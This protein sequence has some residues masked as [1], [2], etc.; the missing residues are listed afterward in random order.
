[1]MNIL[2]VDDEPEIL[3]GLRRMLRG[4][5]DR[6][7]MQFASSSGEALEAMDATQ[8]DVIVS[9]MRMPGMD[10]ASL[11]TEA[12]DRQPG[13]VRIVLSGQSQLSNS[14][15]SLPVA[16]QF[17]A[18]PCDP[19]RLEAA[20]ERSLLLRDRMTSP[21]LRD[22]VGGLDC[23]PSP[24]GTVVALQSALAVRPV[25]PDRVT[26]LINADIAIST[27]VL[28]VAN[29]AFFGLP[30]TLAD[31]VEAVN[32][33]GA[34]A[35]CELVMSSEV[36][37]SLAGSN[38]RVDAEIERVQ[39][40]GTMR[41][42][43]ASELARRAGRSAMAAREIWVSAFLADVGCLLLIS[44]DRPSCAGWDS[45]AAEDTSLRTLVPT[46]GGYLISMWGLPHHLVEAVALSNDRPQPHGSDPAAFTWVAR[47]LLP[48][49]P[50]RDTIT[51]DDLALVGIAREDLDAVA[52][53]VQE[54]ADA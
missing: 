36:F 47:H 12:R 21:E 45:G 42:D 24:S 1:M 41:A 18:K 50:D 5:R 4:R 31:P 46:I 33:L 16:H 39:A 28:Q 9:D 7:S 6:W 49:G 8:F 19:A 26:E 44:A 3:A 11:L 48:E 27:K 17:L 22:L 37:R 51:D 52:G 10:G 15:R 14:I 13:A 29:S 32:Y 53:H 40:R 23:L 25:D 43:M 35:L 20:I 54:H 34:Q 38:A 2:F 30:R